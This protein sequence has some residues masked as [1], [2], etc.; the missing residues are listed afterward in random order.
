MTEEQWYKLASL[1]GKKIVN[2]AFSFHHIQD[3][4]KEKET[5]IDTRQK[6][7]KKIHTIKPEAF[8]LV[9][10]NSNHNTSN[11]WYRFQNAWE[12]FRLVF[13]VIDLLKLKTEEQFLIKNCFF[14][15]E[16]DDILS[17]QEDSRCERHETVDTWLQR[18][19]V[20]SFQTRNLLSFS[21]DFSPSIVDIIINNK[22]YIGIQYKDTFIVTVMC[23]QT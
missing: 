8:I 15:R 4:R 23:G 10:P 3:K 16:I 9:E 11:L 5:G 2:S 22:G 13:E 17:N 14:A 12:H 7:I 1:P 6:I 19:S 18:L 21:I 20:A